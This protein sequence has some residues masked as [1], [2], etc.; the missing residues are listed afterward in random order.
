M[1]DSCYFEYLVVHYVYHRIVMGE[2]NNQ[3]VL[4]FVFSAVFVVLLAVL[5]VLFVVIY[6]KRLVHQEIKLQKLQNERQK[7]LLK[8]SIE[9]QERER[10]RLA[11]DLH[12]GIGSLLS[13]LSLHLKFQKSQEDVGT[14]RAMFL[15]E[16]CKMVDEGIAN[17]RTVSHNLLPPTLEKFGLISAIKESIEPLNNGPNFKVNLQT[18]IPTKSTVAKDISL[19]ILRIFQEL[20]QNTIK[21]SNAT[22]VDILLM[23]EEDKIKMHY[24]DNGQGM[25]T[26]LEEDVDGIGLKNIRSRIEALEGNYD[27]KSS[28]GSGFTLELLIPN[29]SKI[30]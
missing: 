11:K 26:H 27:F 7:V 4:I 25:D 19:G 3:I 28:S 13:G 10:E 17:I 12:D 16:A 23:S 24:K 30:N 18:N 29:Y 2:E 5:L 15:E 1:V 6:Q 8:A 20:I 14:Q 22:Q 9:G 21:H